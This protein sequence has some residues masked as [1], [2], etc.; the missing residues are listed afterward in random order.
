MDPLSQQIFMLSGDYLQIFSQDFQLL[1]ETLIFKDNKTA[2]RNCF[3][4]LRY[5]QIADATKSAIYAIAICEQNG[6]LIAAPVNVTNPA[7]PE[8]NS[9]ILTLQNAVGFDEAQCFGE[10]IIVLAS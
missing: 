4:L 2:S 10:D 1:S 9:R 5:P 6:S 3:Q 7:S 8:M